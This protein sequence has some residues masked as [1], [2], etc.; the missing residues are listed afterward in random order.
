MIKT[1]KFTILTCLCC[2]HTLIGQQLS[3]LDYAELQ[4]KFNTNKS[5]DTLAARQYAS[6]YLQ[7]AKKANE[8]S[9]IAEGYYMYSETLLAEKA[10]PHL[11]SIINL[12]KSIQDFNYP[13]KA[14]LRKAQIY[15]GKSQFRKAMD[16]LVEANRLA[17]QNNNIDQKYKIEYFIGLLKDDLGESEEAL[18]IFK[19][20]V[21]YYTSK[22]KEN[23]SYKYD[24]IR[25]LF[26]LAFIYEKNNQN[27][28]AF[29]NSKKAIE[30]IKTSKDSTLYGRLVLTSGVV[31]YNKKEYQASLDSIQK[32]KNIAKTIPQS[33]GTLI[34]S[35]LYQGRIFNALGN[36]EKALYHLKKVDSAAFATK[37]FYPNMRSAYELLIKLNKEKGN[38]KDQLLYIDRLLEADSILDTNYKEIYRKMNK[39]YTTPNLVLEKQQIIRDLQKS[40]QHTIILLIILS[41]AIISLTIILIRN[42]KKRKIYKQ[43]FLEIYNKEESEQQETS[44]PKP[45][46]NKTSEEHKESSTDIGI[47]EIIVNDILKHLENFEQSHGFLT[48]NITVSSLAKEFKTNSKYLSKVIN[49]HK[50]KSFSNY[51]NDLRIELTVKRLKSDSKFRKYTIKAIANEMGFNT[52]EAFSKSFYKSNGIFPSFFLKELEKKLQEGEEIA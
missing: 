10:L 7:K 25:S 46:A 49:A 11:D 22:T 21:A 3:S 19:S 20:N 33:N 32:F 12:T 4:V 23:P 50:N 26:A 8:L 15:G 47:S 44:T 34:R 1:F 9:N 52:T 18:E 29:A 14:H 51:V 17:H 6:A 28:E 35:N 24:Y 43:R 48:P 37:Y 2:L 13:A 41:I 31:H 27:D 38:T 39:E 5:T 45:K 36:N 40:N 30:L 42:N 16:E